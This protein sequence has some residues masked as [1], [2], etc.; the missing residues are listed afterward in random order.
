MNVTYGS[1]AGV[2]NGSPGRKNE[3]SVFAHLTESYGRDG[4]KRKEV[5][6]PKPRVVGNNLAQGYPQ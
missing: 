2:R 1:A 6:I 5:D 4:L 3:S